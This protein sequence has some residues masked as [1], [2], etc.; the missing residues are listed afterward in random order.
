MESLK[1]ENLSSA[2]LS[3]S[4]R[5]LIITSNIYR[6]GKTPALVITSGPEIL[7]NSQSRG[8]NAI[9]VVGAAFFLSI[10]LAFALDYVD[11]IKADPESSAKIRKALGK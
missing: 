6:E 4:V 1:S 3:D 10:F 5:Q 2:G 7:I 11:R 8:K 9:I